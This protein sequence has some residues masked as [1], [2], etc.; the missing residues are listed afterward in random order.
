ML[1]PKRSFSEPSGVAVFPAARPVESKRSWVIPYRAIEP[2][3]VAIDAA[4][5]F[6]TAALSDI[7]YSLAFTSSQG[8][9]QQF[10]GFAAVVSVLFILIARSRDL[11][12]LPELLNFKSQIRLISV[13]WCAIFLFLTA[14]AFAIKWA[15][16]FRAARRSAL[17]FPASHAF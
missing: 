1:N 9:I 4:I 2:L 6:I 11:Y 3:A 12:A 14:V 13:N 5:I 15:A 17:L 7:A 16:T 10:M 8:N